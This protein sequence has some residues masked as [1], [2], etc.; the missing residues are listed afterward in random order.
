ML[1]RRANVARER[2]RDAVARVLPAADSTTNRHGY[3]RSNLAVHPRFDERLK[4]ARSCPSRRR[5]LSSASAPKQTW[6]TADITGCHREKR[7]PDLLLYGCTDWRLPQPGIILDNHAFDR[8][9]Q[10][11]V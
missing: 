11:A 10:T 3:Q 5:G 4:S 2:V 7:P 9:T 1:R 8:G 6:A